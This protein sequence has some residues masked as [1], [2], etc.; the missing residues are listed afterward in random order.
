M[1]N[2]LFIL[3]FA[4]CQHISFGQTPFSKQPI[5]TLD[6]HHYKLYA[7][8]TAVPAQ[9]K[10]PNAIN[11][12]GKVVVF[13][14]IEHYVI[15]RVE[16]ETFD[17]FTGI[18]VYDTQNKINKKVIFPLHNSHYQEITIKSEK[19]YWSF[20]LKKQKWSE[21]PITFQ[22]STKDFGTTWIVKKL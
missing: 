16:G 13:D 2:L 19:D 10:T 17:Y 8:L 21:E 5:D 9:E 3:G 20:T 14:K 1:K 7:E 18:L 11:L 15:S 22:I 4:L 12:S 6:E